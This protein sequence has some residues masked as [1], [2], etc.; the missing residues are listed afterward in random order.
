MKSLRENLVIL[1]LPL[2]VLSAGVLFAGEAAA[3]KEWVVKRQE[4]FEF[5]QR[6][7]IRRNGDKVEISFESKAACDVTVALEDGQGKI[8]R[9]LASG[10]L[11]DNAP[12]P[13]KPN[14]LKQTI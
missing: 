5:A 6:P 11:G 8:V 10:V 9:H 7:Q 2:V 14:S 3:N 12:A 13:L 4:I 1:Y